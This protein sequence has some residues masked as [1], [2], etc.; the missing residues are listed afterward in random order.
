MGSQTRK[1]ERST[2]IVDEEKLQAARREL[3]SDLEQAMRKFAEAG[4]TLDDVVTTVLLL[5]A[6]MAVMGGW[7]AEKWAVQA[8]ASFDREL[9]RLQ[10]VR[11]MGGGDG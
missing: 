10:A 9:Q 2:G 7:P 6:Q 3:A 11:Q 5:S 8:G 1:L 4:H